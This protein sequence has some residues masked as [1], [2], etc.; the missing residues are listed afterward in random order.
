[1]LTLPLCFYK[2]YFSVL[3]VGSQKHN[4]ASVQFDTVKLHLE[5][6][7]TSQM[8]RVRHSLHDIIACFETLEHNL[9]SPRSS[10]YMFVEVVL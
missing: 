7:E 1:M 8:A 2:F 10:P 5:F 3:Q 9:V 6:D 4:K